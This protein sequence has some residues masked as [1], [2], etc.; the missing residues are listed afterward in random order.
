[1][2]SFCLY[3]EADSLR[4]GAGLPPT[5]RAW[6]APGSVRGRRA[7]RRRRPKNFA[8]SLHRLR[9]NHSEGSGK[10]R[11]TNWRPSTMATG[12]AITLTAM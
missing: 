6:P 3:R 4:V 1:M 7:G 8:G 9:V 5:R 2:K 12:A 10:I 11:M